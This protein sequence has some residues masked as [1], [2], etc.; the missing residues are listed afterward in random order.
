MTFKIEGVERVSRKLGAVVDPG[1]LRAQAMAA[2]MTIANKMKEYPVQKRVTR[3]QA[4]GRSFESDKQRRYFFAA[5]RDGK[6]RVPYRRAMSGGLAGKWRVKSSGVTGAEIQNVAPY[7]Q[8]VQGERSQSR[9][10]QMIGWPTLER[11]A[12]DMMDEIVRKLRAQI[13]RKWEA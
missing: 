10:M 3:K 6:I 13:R 12:R 11:T 4:F 8:W 7:G 1:F 5:L 9:M 2:G